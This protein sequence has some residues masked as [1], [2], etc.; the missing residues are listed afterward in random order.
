[1]EAG[2]DTRD[3]L[4]MQMREELALR[5]QLLDRQLAEIAAIRDAR[6]RTKM[7]TTTRTTTSR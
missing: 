6:Q 3:Q 4:W 5:K 7:R 2:E 1:M